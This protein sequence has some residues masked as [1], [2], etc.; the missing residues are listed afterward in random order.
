[1]IFYSWERDGLREKRTLWEALKLSVNRHRAIA[2]TGG[3]GKTSVMFRLADELADMGKTVI[4]TTTTHIFNPPDR[5]VVESGC[6]SD[7]AKWLERNARKTNISG[8]NGNGERIGSG[9]AAGNGIGSGIG[10]GSGKGTVLVVGVPAADGKLKSL[11]LAET[12]RLKG[13]ADIL[14]FEAD[15][16]KRLPIKVPKDGEPVIPDCTDAV[17]GC[18]GLNCIG[19]ELEEFC[20]RTEQAAALLGVQKEP[21]GHYSHR[22]TCSDAAKILTSESGT[23]KL[24]GGRD[25]RI[26]INKADDE[27]L[28]AKA[29]RIA[30]ELERLYPVPCAVSCLLNQDRKRQGNES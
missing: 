4:V 13:L 14:L 11:S 19:G 12:A 5:N 3:G 20:F 22:I 18:M 24:V 30:K 21:E 10:S 26:V 25:Y 17:I 15:G 16:A 23:R 9:S 28:L 27:E 2:L 7:A 29:A 8:E 1:M 6:A